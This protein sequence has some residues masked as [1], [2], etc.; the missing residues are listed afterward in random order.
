[1][2]CNILKRIAKRSAPRYHSLSC[3]FYFS[4]SRATPNFINIDNTPFAIRQFEPT[5]NFVSLLL[6]P[7]VPFSLLVLLPSLSP[8]IPSYHQHHQS[9]HHHQPSHRTDAH[10]VCFNLI[11]VPLFSNGRFFPDIS[12]LFI[13]IQLIIPNLP[14]RSCVITRVGDN[15]SYQLIFLIN[16]YVYLKS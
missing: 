15:S 11:S 4:R 16:S 10:P 12:S 8:R 1:M 5:L 6:P 3:S 9:R 2:S 13:G 14:A 7:S